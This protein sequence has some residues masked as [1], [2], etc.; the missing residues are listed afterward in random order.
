MNPDP[1]ST[2]QAPVVHKLMPTNRVLCWLK[3]VQKM[4][5]LF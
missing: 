1:N 5:A 4:W 3:Q 2:M